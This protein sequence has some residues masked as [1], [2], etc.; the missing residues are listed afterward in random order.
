M[1]SYIGYAVHKSKNGTGMVGIRQ[2]AKEMRT[3]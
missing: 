1:D 3:Y 2:D